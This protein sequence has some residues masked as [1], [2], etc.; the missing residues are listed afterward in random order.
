MGGFK[1]NF[2][3]ERPDACPPLDAEAPDGV[4]YRAVQS[5]PISADDFLSWVRAEKPSARRNDCRHWGLSVWT[6]LEAVIH[7][8]DISDSIAAQCIAAA[9]L[10]RVDGVIKATPT[11]NQP[12]HHTLWCNVNVDV[13]GKFAIIM[14]PVDED[15]QSAEEDA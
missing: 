1:L 3:P 5:D 4:I 7:A 6:S 12:E 13:K 11:K 9:T 2:D 14:H 15:M 10:G 8:R